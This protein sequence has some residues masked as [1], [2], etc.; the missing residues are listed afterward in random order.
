MG[1]T[2]RRN[3]RKWSNQIWVVVILSLPRIIPNKIETKVLGEVKIMLD[4]FCMSP[5]S[6]P[7]FKARELK[8][9][10]GMAQN[11]QYRISIFCLEACIKWNFK[12][13][14]NF[15]GLLS[16]L[17]LQ[18][19]LFYK[20]KISEK[21]GWLNVRPVFLRSARLRSSVQPKGYIFTDKEHIWLTLWNI[22]RSASYQF[23]AIRNREMLLLK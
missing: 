13:Y 5:H 21:G 18:H 8:T 20:V 10:K 6:P 14:S 4:S 11:L 3:L 17:P 9:G 23:W 22:Y 19:D 12:L 15:E 7:S 1:Q 16:S 2:A